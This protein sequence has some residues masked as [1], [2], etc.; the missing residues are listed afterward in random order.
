MSAIV[1]VLPVSVT[2]DEAREWLKLS[3]A[4]GGLM[5]EGVR[6]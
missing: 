6:A 2:T 1:S 5:A 3:K 4:A